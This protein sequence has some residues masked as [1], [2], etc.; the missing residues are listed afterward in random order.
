MPTAPSIIAHR[1]QQHN[2]RIQNG[3]NANVVVATNGNGNN[4]SN[5]NGCAP[6]SHHR[7]AAANTA[8]A[9][10]TVD[11][12]AKMAP[13]SRKKGIGTRD[14]VDAKLSEPRCCCGLVRIR[15]VAIV[16]G[17]MEFVF[18]ATQLIVSLVDLFGTADDL[19]PKSASTLSIL[20]T[21]IS[22][23]LAIA[24]AMLLVSGVQF[25]SPYLLVPHIL[26]QFAFMIASLVLIGYLFS[27]WFGGFK[28][29]IS[30]IVYENSEKGYQGLLTAKDRSPVRGNFAVD[31][32]N[33]I[34]LLMIIFSGI[35]FVI[36][37]WLYHLIVS[38]L[39][40]MLKQPKAISSLSP[41]HSDTVDS[42]TTVMMMS[43][44]SSQCSP[45]NGNTYTNGHPPHSS[46]Q[47][48]HII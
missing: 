20:L 15:H 18:F 22:L 23:I 7:S 12:Q 41:T 3:H 32:F 34:V 11:Q 33:T 10:P 9:M 47:Q 21:I 1:H 48:Q 19:W 44:V 40:D 42:C 37:L 2:D 43:T 24:A 13:T 36:Q 5:G 27:W 35:I 30:A 14:I 6:I 39:R 45:N 8:L 26:M 46:A 29:R 31:E 4:S 25:R 28:I 38:L 17:V 16:L